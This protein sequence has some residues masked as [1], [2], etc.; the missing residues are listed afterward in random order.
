[1]ANAPEGYLSHF[2]RMSH[3]L[4]LRRAGKNYQQIADI[5][6][7][8][9]PQRAQKLVSTAIKR[10][11]KETAE[12]V[13]TIELSRLDVL[14]ECLWAKA[15]DDVKKDNPEYARFDRLKALLETKLRWCGAQQVV[16][17]SDKS[18]TIVVQSFTNNQ[19]APAIPP[20]LQQ[21]EQF[22]DE[23]STQVDN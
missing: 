18:V 23:P 21:I 10:V 12:E 17:Q 1:M 3:A 20:P 15:L 11:L 7:L 19:S 5:T 9:S 2:A 4:E 22:I 16:D 13:R 6:G 8:S 14:I